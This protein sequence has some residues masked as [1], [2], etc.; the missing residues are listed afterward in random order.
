MEGVKL[1]T[2]LTAK[3]LI[4]YFVVVAGGKSELGQFAANNGDSLLTEGEK[5]NFE[6]IEEDL[7]RVKEEVSKGAGI[8]HDFEDS[9]ASRVPWLERMTLPSHLKD[10]FDEEIYGSYKVP[11]DR[12]PEGGSFDD[13]ILHVPSPDPISLKR[14]VR[15]V[16]R[17]IPGP[18]DDLPARVYPQRILYRSQ[19]EVGRI[20]PL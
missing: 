6:T 11:S 1:Q 14:G 17:H 8:V 13:P 12:E 3:G 16:Q 9:R 10:L 5:A 19:R 7:E 4:D 20:S 2:Y 15:V 18:E